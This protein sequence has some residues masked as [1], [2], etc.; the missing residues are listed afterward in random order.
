MECALRICE[1]VTCS[2]GASA[3]QS[4]DTENDTECPIAPISQLTV[5]Q[6]FRSDE[7][8]VIWRDLFESN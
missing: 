8:R 1:A 6:R 3:A 4:E 5:T 2:T 7:V